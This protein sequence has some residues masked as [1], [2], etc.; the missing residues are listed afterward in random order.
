MGGL[1]RQ[2]WPAL[3]IRPAAP[4]KFRRKWKRAMPTK[5]GTS[6]TDTLFTCNGASLSRMLLGWFFSH[7]FSVFW[8]WFDLWLFAISSWCWSLCS[9]GAV[10]WHRPGCF[11]WGRQWCGDYSMEIAIPFLGVDMGRSQSKCRSGGKTLVKTGADI[12][13]LTAVPVSATSWKRS[14]KLRNTSNSVGPRH[15]LHSSPNR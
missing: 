12:Q 13:A 14:W 3:P 6:A 7:L 15:F 5:T 1:V 10:A 9:L 8:I 11:Y 2:D 4:Q